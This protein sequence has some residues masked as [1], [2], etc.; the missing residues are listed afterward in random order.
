[1]PALGDENI[2]G[3]DVAMN[4]VFAMSGI[5]RFG[6][7]DGEVEEPLEVHRLAGYGVLQSLAVQ[8]LHGD[9]RAA[10][11][12]SDIV[13]SADIG[14]IQGRSGLRFALELAS[15]CGSLATSSGRNL[16]ATNRCRRVSSA[17]KTTPI[18]PPPI[19]SVMR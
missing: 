12:R 9:E 3:L 4:D 13:D 11:F 1:M 6:N 18:P 17:L 10:I 2:G 14:M 7:L 15:A 19:F 16:R 5:E 8:I